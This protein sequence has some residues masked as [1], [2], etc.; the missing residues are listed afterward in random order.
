M[1]KKHKG[2][3]VKVGDV[4]Y[5]VVSTFTVLHKGWASDNTGYVVKK[6]EKHAIVL[7]SHGRPYL[8]TQHD[9]M[10]TLT[11]MERAAQEARHA[12]AMAFL[13]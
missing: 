9:F 13:P 12:Y 2:Q 8:A 7:T 5:P 3:T 6:G 4:D 1:S 10:E 11:E